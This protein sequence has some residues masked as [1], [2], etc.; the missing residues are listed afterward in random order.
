MS[1]LYP[2]K[3]KTIYKDKIW[4]GHKIETYLHK[5]FGDLPNCGETWEISGV[6]SDVSVVDG[7]ALDGES[8]A[9]LLE[10]YKD[11]LVGKKVYDHF[12][13]I[14]PLLIKFIDAND[15]LSIQV[16]PND[17][18]A[19][20]RHNSFGKTEMWYVIEADPGSSLITGFNGHLEPRASECRRCFLFT[21]RP[22]AHH[23]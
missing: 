11:E 2:L 16:H 15:D 1:S 22:C 18:L 5:D 9:D 3:F 8:L 21:R 4:G 20:K 19:K 14:F 10:Q 12:G 13:N 23:W 7:G 6:K 17:E